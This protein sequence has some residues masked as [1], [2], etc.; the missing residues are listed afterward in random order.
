MQKEEQRVFTRHEFDITVPTTFYI[1]SDGYQ[2][3]FGGS[4]GRKLMAKP[5][6]EIL[7]ENSDKPFDWQEKHLRKTFI[8]WR[9]DHIQMDDTTVIGIKLS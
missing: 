8:E 3:Q 7:T 4:L 2:D 1:Y 6:R 5:F 9:G